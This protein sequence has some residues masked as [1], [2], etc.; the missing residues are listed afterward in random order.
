MMKLKNKMMMAVVSSTILPVALI[1]FVLYQLTI[2]KIVTKEKIISKKLI[3]E[4]EM[5]VNLEVENAI[6]DIKMLVKTFELEKKEQG[7]SLLEKTAEYQKKYI[8]IYYYEEKT[9]EMYIYS[10]S[11]I[12]RE[13]DLK[14]KPWGNIALEKDYKI[15]KIHLDE[16]TKKYIVNI[17][18][19]VYI[20]NNLEGVIGIDLDLDKVSKIINL[21]NRN[22]ISILSNQG[23]VLID[24]D[25][26]IIGKDL[27]NLEYIKEIVNKKT[28]S[29]NYTVGKE[30]KYY[31][32]KGLAEYDWIIIIELNYKE[33]RTDF[34]DFKNLIYLTILI[35]L[36]IN[37]LEINLFIN[38]IINRLKKINDYTEKIA[39][40]D[41]TGQIEI[42][43]KDEI[44]EIIL[45]IGKVINR[46]IKII[47]EIKD[48]GK[49]IQRSSEKLKEVSERLAQKTSN[50]ATSL[51]E[52][53]STMEEISSLVIK[54]TEKTNEA[55]IIIKET[56]EKTIEVGEMS[57]NLK[58]AM[59]LITESSS[60][61]ENIIEVIAEIGFQTNLLA[62]N[63]AVEAARAG[64]AGKGFA[65]VAVEIRNLAGRSSKASKEIKELI[66]ENGI[67]TSEGN[68]YLQETMDK[69]NQIVEKIKKISKAINEINVSAEEEQKGIE[70]I[71]L[72]IAS[73]D[74][75]TQTNAGIAE[76]TATSASVLLE[77]ASSFLN[78]VNF[79]RIDKKDN[80]T[81]NKEIK[82]GKKSK[83]NGI[84]KKEKKIKKIEKEL[85]P[86]DEDIEEI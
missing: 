2:N 29:F 59:D 61:I 48:G 56:K 30:K 20:D 11:E 54:N 81:N 58:G 32:F 33:I 12:S 65:V 10:K 83:K 3:E 26:E 80:K 22:K 66:K 55:N 60:K 67:R 21:E 77:R 53:S 24:K 62:L 49:E 23:K 45:E 17:S 85:I 13:Y 40:G 37:L 41:Y 44:G 72:T 27:N 16:I 25:K 52:T 18:K 34:F 50:Q 6:K 57:L 5:T 15:S 1:M 79:F 47:G 71:N 64:E 69:L 19:T 8:N 9:R 63:A 68:I 86:F 70:Q 74:N 82:E 51:E 4:I 84:E 76:E 73:L 31:I 46:Q 14:S 75:I 36:V 78:I 39:M 42:Q 7:L 43:S 28:G 38:S 35:L